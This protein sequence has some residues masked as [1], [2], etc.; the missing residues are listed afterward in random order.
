MIEDAIEQS[1][2]PYLKDFDVKKLRELLLKTNN[3]V[4]CKKEMD[5]IKVGL[6]KSKIDKFRSKL[7]PNQ[8]KNS[9]KQ[10]PNAERK[11]EKLQ[12][13]E[14]QSKYVEVFGYYPLR[15]DFDIEHDCEAENYI[16]D[17]EFEGRYLSKDNDTDKEIEL[18]KEILELFNKRLDERIKRKN[19]VIDHGLLDLERQAVL[20]RAPKE[21]KAI[22]RKLAVFERFHSQ[23]E[24]DELVSTVLKI[25]EL[26]RRIKNLEELPQYTNFEDIEV[27]F[28]YEETPIGKTQ[29]DEPRF[30]NE[31]ATRQNFGKSGIKARICTLILPRNSLAS[32]TPS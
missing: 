15:R 6:T 24:H 16:A 21:V 30:Q 7:Y 17:M 10:N 26:N 22:R 18:K 5:L 28:L 1:K 27:P 12:G 4:E 14:Q 13:Q 2:G 3:S 19:F 11:E 32:A 31:E 20:D 23:A 8:H 29:G 25:R 9:K